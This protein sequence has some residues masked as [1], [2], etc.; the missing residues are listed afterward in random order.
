MANKIKKQLLA[1]SRAFQLNSYETRE[2][3]FINA[4]KASASDSILMRC[5]FSHYKRL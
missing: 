3:Y 4:C 2:R 1:D 5:I